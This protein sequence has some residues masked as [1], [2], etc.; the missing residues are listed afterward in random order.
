VFDLELPDQALSCIDS[1][2]RWQC[3]L[4]VMFCCY[5]L[6][7]N[8]FHSFWSDLLLQLFMTLVIKAPKLRLD[9]KTWWSFHHLIRKLLPWPCNETC[10]WQTERSLRTEFI[11]FPA[12][13]LSMLLYIIIA[14]YCLSCVVARMLLICGFGPIMNLVFTAYQTCVHEWNFASRFAKQRLNA[15]WQLKFCRYPGQF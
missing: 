9:A 14:S 15:A 8:C 10:S 13:I 5:L 4:C 11:P 1:N 7:K 6:S 12:H 2:L 3:F